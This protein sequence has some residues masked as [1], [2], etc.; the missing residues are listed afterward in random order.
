[1]VKEGHLSGVD[2]QSSWPS[3]RLVAISDESVLAT[4]IICLP[5][6]TTVQVLNAARVY[7]RDARKPEDVWWLFQSK[8]DRRICEMVEWLGSNCAGLFD[9]Y[10]YNI[11]SG[12]KLEVFIKD[13]NVALRF[14]A[15]FYK[16][17]NLHE[18][19]HCIK[20]HTLRRRS[21]KNTPTAIDFLI[22][23]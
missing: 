10:C 9:D 3:V 5:S 23:K 14:K 15:R 6:A 17:L 7:Y 4:E 2:V 18:T 11:L 19:T 22:I 16:S 21:T 1:M 12:R 13:N 8:I 20:N